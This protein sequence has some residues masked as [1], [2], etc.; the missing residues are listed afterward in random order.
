MTAKA[1][2]TVDLLRLKDNKEI[3][4][5]KVTGLLGLLNGVIRVIKFIA[6]IRGIRVVIF[7][8]GI[9]AT[10]FIVGIRVIRLLDLLKW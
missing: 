4:V 8:A 6:V 5:T 1:M 2:R 10:I 9:R 3:I 7:I